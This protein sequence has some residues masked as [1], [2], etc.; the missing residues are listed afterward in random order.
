[1]RRS[2]P[3]GP[4][5]VVSRVARCAPWRMASQAA[6]RAPVAPSPYRR[7]RHSSLLFRFVAQVDTALRGTARPLRGARH[8][9]LSSKLSGVVFAMPSAIPRAW[10][11]ASCASR[12][13]YA[14]VVVVFD[15]S[16]LAPNFGP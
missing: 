11:C 12:A 10:R 5:A 6:L 13:L 7:S 2:F 1:M 8:F 16:F 9:L 15:R 4:F 14:A 3:L